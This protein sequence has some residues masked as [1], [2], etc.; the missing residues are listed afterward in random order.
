MDNERHITQTIIDVHD[1]QQPEVNYQMQ[2]VKPELDLN[3]LKTLSGMLKCICITLDFVCFICLVV[4]GPAIYRGVGWMIFIC[5]IAMLV[6][7]VLLI[8]YLF[9]IV[10]IL[11][12]I[13]WIVSFFS[14]G[15]L[16]AYGFDSYLKFLAWR[17][18]EVA[19]GGRT[20][21]YLPH[22]DIMVLSEANHAIE[23]VES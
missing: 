7:L 18:D 23:V 14:F 11:H 13:P 19:T 17:H 20:L 22:A 3:Y 8:F 10:D 1:Y 4:G 9:H 5:I 15:A 12:Q 21:K 6:S 16:C 2:I